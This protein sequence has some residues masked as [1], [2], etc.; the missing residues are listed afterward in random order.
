MAQKTPGLDAAYSLRTPEDS[1]QL[2]RDWAPS[3]DSDFAKAMDYRLPQRLVAAFADAF[4][5]EG[6]VLDV[7]AGTGLVAQ[8]LAERGIGPVEGVDISAEMLGIAAQ[9]AVYSRLFVGDVTRQLEVEDG[10]YAGILSAGTFTLGHV[11][12]GA[13]DEL[14]RVARPG[15]LIAITVNEAHWQAAGFAEKFAQ[16]AGK[17]S[18]LILQRCA[19]YGDGA[20]DTHAGDM[21]KIALFRKV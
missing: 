11:G 6:P 20:D 16:L 5:G 21:G 18:D 14:L 7:G 4:G 17:I 3:Y 13:L 10:R 2:Y 12:P 15:A 8:H 19:I 1:V 9:K